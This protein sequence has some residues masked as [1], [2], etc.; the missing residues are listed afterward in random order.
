MVYF[1]HA[2]DRYLEL[3]RAGIPHYD[4]LQDEVIRAIAPLRVSRLLDLGVGSGETSR[5]CLEA[6]PHARIVGIDQSQAMLDVAAQV[7]G[8]RVRLQLGRLEDPLPPGPFDAV[9]SA[10]AVHHLDGPAKAD[11]FER[12]ACCLAPAGRFVLADLVVP[13]GPVT[14]PIPLTSADTPDRVD[15]MLEWLRAAGLEPTVRWQHQDLMV[16]EASVRVPDKTPGLLPPGKRLGEA[17]ASP[18]V[19]DEQPAAEPWWHAFIADDADSGPASG[20]DRRAP[21]K[22][23]EE[24]RDTEPPRAEHPEE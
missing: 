23:P 9:V 17:A 4:R 8:D 1:L 6:H 5:R 18:P 10:L 3:I 24:R 12:I 7:L 11:L 13:A 16:L 19:E 15:D 2:P 21:D 14:E 20:V 22:A